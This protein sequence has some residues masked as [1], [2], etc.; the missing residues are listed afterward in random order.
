MIH[1]TVLPL[2]FNISPH[3]LVEFMHDLAVTRYVAVAGC[4]LLFYDWL[5]TLDD[6]ITYIW[7]SRWSST[8]AI[9]LLNRYV[10]LGLQLAVEVH[11]I[12][13]TPVKSHSTCVSYIVGY[14]ITVFISLASIHVLVLLR[15][16]I[17]WQRRRAVT[18]LLG[19]I[20]TLYALVCVGL[21]IHAA[22]TASATFIFDINGSCTTFTA[23]IL[24]GQICRQY[25]AESSS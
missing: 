2:P 5:I 12:G 6:E 8:K 3:F 16:W 22:I 15:T 20:Y 14:G 7:P 11:L 18:V 13:L 24:V 19:V 9:F 1:H 25:A 17:V 10:N 23:P 21:I 4:V